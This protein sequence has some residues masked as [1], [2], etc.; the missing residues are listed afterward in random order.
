MFK[1]VIPDPEEGLHDNGKTIRAGIYFDILL[2]DIKFKYE[3]NTGNF[4]KYYER[5]FHF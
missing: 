2:H 5:I 3:L 1:Y 4:K